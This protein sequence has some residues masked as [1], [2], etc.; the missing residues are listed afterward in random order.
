MK[1]LNYVLV[2]KFYYIK[3]FMKYFYL[4]LNKYIVYW[5]IK[6]VNSLLGNCFFKFNILVIVFL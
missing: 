6:I 2:N 3:I 5:L 4:L 1:G